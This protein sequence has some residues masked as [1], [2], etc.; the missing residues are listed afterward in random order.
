MRPSFKLLLQFLCK[1][2]SSFNL[3]VFYYLYAWSC[4]LCEGRTSF[5]TG[6]ISRKLCRFLLM[7]LI[8]LLYSVS[9]FFFLYQS[10]SLSLST[11]FYSISSNIDKVLVINLFGNIFVYGVITVHHKDSGSLLDLRLRFL[12]SCSFGF[13]SFF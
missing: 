5:C 13:I 9:Y 3:K 8:G 10:P 11:V 4:S 6:F 7:F 12:Q 2:L 1:G